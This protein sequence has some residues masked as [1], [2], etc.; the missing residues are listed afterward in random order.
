MGEGSSCASEGTLVG[1]VLGPS[2]APPSG[3]GRNSA[4]KK[5]AHILAGTSRVVSPWMRRSFVDRQYSPSD[6]MDR[7]GWEII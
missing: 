3:C 2:C 6:S 1:V 4:K 7:S 5:V